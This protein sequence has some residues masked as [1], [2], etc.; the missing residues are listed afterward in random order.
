MRF[1]HAHDH[2]IAGFG[3]GRQIAARP[4]EPLIIVEH[5]YG[6]LAFDLIDHAV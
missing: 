2:G 3:V 1:G 5:D 6:D 4:I